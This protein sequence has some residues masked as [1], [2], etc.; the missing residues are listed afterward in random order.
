M[1]GFVPRCIVLHKRIVAHTFCLA[2]PDFKFRLGHLTFA[3]TGK[4]FFI[5]S[6]MDFPNVVVVDF[7]FEAFC[8]AYFATGLSALPQCR[9]IAV[10]VRCTRS[11]QKP[12]ATVRAALR[13]KTLLQALHH[14][15]VDEIQQSVEVHLLDN[16]TLS[17]NFAAYTVLGLYLRC[18]DLRISAETHSAHKRAEVVQI[19]IS[20]SRSSVP[21]K[22]VVEGSTKSGRSRTVAVDSDIAGLIACL[23][24]EKEREANERGEEISEYIFTNEHGKLIHPDTFS[25]TLRKIYDSIGLPHEFHLHT[26]R[27]YYVTTLLHSGVDKQTVA[28]L[29]GH[30]DTSFL[31]RTYCHPRLDKKRSAAEAFAAVQFGESIRSRP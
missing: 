6:L 11:L 10:R 19:N 9:F 27:H 4:V 2:R 16:L 31:E 3:H 26:L 15:D 24:T 12:P 28:D 17:L 30:C 25:K 21:G 20:R 29:V 8:R 13:N 22:G 1:R 7:L 18:V 5:C 14:L 23:Y